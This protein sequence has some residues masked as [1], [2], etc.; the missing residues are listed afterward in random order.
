MTWGGDT[1]FLE[2]LGGY[3]ENQDENLD[4]KCLLGREF[5]ESP[6]C[7]CK[8][9]KKGAH[10]R[11]DI[12]QPPMRKEDK[13]HLEHWQNDVENVHRVIPALGGGHGIQTPFLQSFWMHSGGNNSV[14][15]THW[16]R[17]AIWSMKS[18]QRQLKIRTVCTEKRAWGL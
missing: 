13:C 8:H 15:T 4:P 6:V 11:H 3:R 2:S 1:S 14:P 10:K 16:L 18:R 5:Q 9:G 7:L 17:K 12:Q